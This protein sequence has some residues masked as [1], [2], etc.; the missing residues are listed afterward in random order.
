MPL[1]IESTNTNADNQLT[2]INQLHRFFQAYEREGYPFTP[3]GTIKYMVK[4]T[5]TFVKAAIPE[6][7]L[8]HVRSDTSSYRMV[9]FED[10]WGGNDWS[11][12]YCLK[13][14][15]LFLTTNEYTDLQK[16]LAAAYDDDMPII[17]F[18]IK[19]DHDCKLNNQITYGN[20]AMMHR[21]INQLLA[22]Q[23]T[24]NEFINTNSVTDMP[25]TFDLV[26]PDD[27]EAIPLIKKLIN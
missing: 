18:P 12:R 21:S 3:N 24:L 8:W 25:L 19:F 7:Y 4:A 16:K 5:P 17:F 13:I 22:S 9:Y 23:P 15:N 26:D 6:I 14:Q 27:A 2:A 11:S 1:T 10:H 20:S